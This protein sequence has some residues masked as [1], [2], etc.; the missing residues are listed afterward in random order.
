MDEYTINMLGEQEIENEFLTSAEVM[1]L[2]YIGKNTFYRL[3]CSGELSAFRVGKL[4][5]VPRVS[6]QAFIEKNSR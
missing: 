3:V 4:W 2:L 1:N 6:L 5:R